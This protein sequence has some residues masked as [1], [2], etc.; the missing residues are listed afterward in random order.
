[1]NDYFNHLLQRHKG[2]SL[3]VAPRLRARFE[4]EPLPAVTPSPLPPVGQHPHDESP[5]TRLESGAPLPAA[6]A[7]KAPAARGLG[8][9]SPITHP[10]PL[11]SKAAPGHATGDAGGQDAAPGREPVNPISPSSLRPRTHSRS[12][13]PDG[14]PVA[15]QSKAD[16]APPLIAS[17]APRPSVA[18]DDPSRNARTMAI[19]TG[20]DRHGEEQ[21]DKTPTREYDNSFDPG[22]KWTQP[23]AHV[24]PP[25]TASPWPHPEAD[26]LVHTVPKPFDAIEPPVTIGADQSPSGNPLEAMPLGQP[27]TDSDWPI[28]SRLPENHQSSAGRSADHRRGET[29]LVPPAWLAQLQSE[30]QR[31][32]GLQQ[33]SKQ[34]EH[35][36]NVT[37]GRVEVRAQAPAPP[38]P[39][40]RSKAPAALS[41]DDY[42]NQRK[43]RGNR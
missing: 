14:P 4:P 24:G 5:W 1:M 33:H 37:I 35:T 25:L 30:F 8:P 15:S 6:P 2:E 12:Q 28:A 36:V 22:R 39:K 13:A 31:R 20:M 17:S 43:G 19:P 7:P 38:K 29:R 10:L 9:E 32:W 26:S 42:L 23:P 18:P 27:D 11:G 41:L 3:G 21:G 16:D 34:P 40:A